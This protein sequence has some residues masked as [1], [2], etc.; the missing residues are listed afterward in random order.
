MKVGVFCGGLSTQIREYSDNNPKLMIPIG[1]QPILS[2]VMRYYR[3]YGHRG[4]VLCLGCE[5]N[6]I[7]DFFPGNRPQRFADCG[8][9]DHGAN[10]E[11][12]PMKIGAKRSSLREAG[13]TSANGF[14][15][16]ANIPRMNSSSSPTTAMALPM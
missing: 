7:T 16:Y 15:P 13:A 12:S 9:S 2:H 11:A 10:V 1:N 3:Q 5:A 4:F 14:G 6:I 8:V